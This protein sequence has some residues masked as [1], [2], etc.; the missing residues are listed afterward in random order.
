MWLYSAGAVCV[1]TPPVI[2]LAAT[3]RIH[4]DL[5]TAGAIA[6]SALGQLTYYMLLQKA[7][8]IDDLSVVYPVA[9]GLVRYY[10]SVP[11]SSSWGSGPV[12]WHCSVPSPW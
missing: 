12:L 10:W 6:V 2:W 11:L 9:G 3:D 5:L 4:I 7:Y 1:Y 8:S